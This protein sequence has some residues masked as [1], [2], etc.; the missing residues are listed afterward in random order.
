[1]QKAKELKFYSFENNNFVLQS[2]CR[3]FSLVLFFVRKNCKKRLLFL[4][5]KM[6]FITCPGAQT[7]IGGD[8]FAVHIAL[9]AVICAEPVFVSV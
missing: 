2:R 4:T 9:P 3:E 6:C 8:W 1:M 7:T 5:I